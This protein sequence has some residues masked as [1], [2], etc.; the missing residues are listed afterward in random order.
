MAAGMLASDNSL[1]GFGRRGPVLTAKALA[2]PTFG[3]SLEQPMTVQWLSFVET[4]DTPFPFTLL[5]GD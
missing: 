4:E 1:S 3:F 2:T 5:V